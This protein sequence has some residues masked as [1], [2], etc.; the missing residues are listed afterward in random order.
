MPEKLVDSTRLTGI[1]ALT[2]A[3]TVGTT[4]TAEMRRIVDAN[5]T[6]GVT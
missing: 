4:I 3:L 2:I 5:Q 1:V 6:P